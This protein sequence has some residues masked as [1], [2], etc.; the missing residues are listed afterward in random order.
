MRHM[1][2]ISYSHKDRPF[3]DR[4]LLHLKPLMRKNEIQIW[5]DREIRPGQV[6]KE[7]IAKALTAAQ[8]AVLLVSPEF[9]ASD[10]IAENELPPLLESAGK[11]ELAILWIPIS[12]CS[13]TKTALAK[14]QAASDPNAPLKDLSQAQQDRVLTEISEGIKNATWSLKIELDHPTPKTGQILR[15]SGRASFR[16]KVRK[17]KLKENLSDWMQRS[18]LKL[19][20]FV[21]SHSSGWWPQTPVRPN[22]DGIFSG[23]VDVGGGSNR[24]I[25]NTYQIQVCAVFPGQIQWGHASSTLPQVRIVSN[26]IETVRK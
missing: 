18:G 11:N 9:L 24:S 26:A 6:W 17:G 16:P 15:I 21:F 22:H 5:S 8:A 2:F 13:W 7:E 1:I 3:L 25:G 20:P 14:Y 10:F 23:K 4:L 19:V 12:Y